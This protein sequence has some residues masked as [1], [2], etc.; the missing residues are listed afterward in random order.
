MQ[1]IQ[2]SKSFGARD[3][4]RDV[5]FRVDPGDRLAVVGRN[6]EGKTT[7][8]RI[9]AGRLDPDGGRVS[10]P[11]GATVALHDQRPPLG[12]GLTLEGYVAQGVQGAARAER[13]L[14]DLEARM[15]GG[16]AGPDVLGAY[17]Q[18]QARLE[19]AGG[20][21][22][23]AWMERVLRGLGIGD[24]DLERPLDGFSGGELTRASLA[25]ALVSRPDVLLLDEPTN[26]LDIEAVEWLERHH[27][28]AGRGRAAGLPR[29]VAAGVARHRRPRDRPRPVQAL[30]DGLLGVPAG[31]GPGHRPAGRRGR[32]PG[33][34]DRAPGALRHP[35]ARRHQVAAGGLAPEEARQ[36]GAPAG[37][38]RGPPTSR[39]GSPRWS[40]AAGW[41]WR[42][43][44]W[45]SRSPVARW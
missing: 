38:A 10:L 7:L 21:A 15:A 26:H 44:A 25:R 27:R 13:E 11:R 19:R 43:T 36:D 5:S 1:A 6:G 41:C 22:W 28:R 2:L 31:A 40:A 39:S 24:Q 12:T 29:P 4:L 42:A 18:A 30:A 37:A 9:L 34:R 14:A 32:A 33:G 20:Y 3:V 35:L 8:L 23:R 16:D 17:E 45:T